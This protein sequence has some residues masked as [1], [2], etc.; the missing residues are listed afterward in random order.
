[1]SVSPLFGLLGCTAII[2]IIMSVFT[3]WAPWLH[4]HNNNNECVSTVWTPWLHRHNNNN[5]CF[6]TVWTPWLHRHNNNSNE[7]VSTVWMFTIS[8]LLC[9]LSPARTLKWLGCHYVQIMCNI[10]SAYHVQHVTQ[11][12]IFLIHQMF[13][14]PST[15]STSFPLHIPYISFK[16]IMFHHRITSS[17]FIFLIHIYHVPNT[18]RV[19]SS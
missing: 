8:S 16:C 6:S 12:I 10:S 4:C 9:E 17:I 19:S 11:Y 3:V 5:E 7:C 15:P 14:L 13:H 18:S 1:M 2:V